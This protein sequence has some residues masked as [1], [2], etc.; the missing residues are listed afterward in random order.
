[1]TSNFVSAA[2]LMARVLGMP[3][4]GFAIIGHPVS[5]AT[6]AELDAHASTTLDAIDALVLQRNSRS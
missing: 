2:E 6:S 4:Y 5:S 1:M 3:G